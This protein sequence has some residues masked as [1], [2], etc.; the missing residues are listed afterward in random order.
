MFGCRGFV[1][2]EEELCL[3]LDHHPGDAVYQH[4]GREDQQ[5]RHFL[6][7]TLFVFFLLGGPSQ[8]EMEPGQVPEVDAEPSHQV[9]G[10]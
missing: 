10:E 2:E 4:A 6:I 8:C 9:E 1:G 5:K 7:L 3:G